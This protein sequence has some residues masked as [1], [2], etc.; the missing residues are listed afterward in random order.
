MRIILVMMVEIIQ[1]DHI[2]KVLSIVLG[3]EWLTNGSYYSSF[4]CFLSDKISSKLSEIFIR[5][6]IY[7]NI[8]KHQDTLNAPF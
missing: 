6:S 4:I 2:H 3:T 5:Y 1:L 7:K 8:S